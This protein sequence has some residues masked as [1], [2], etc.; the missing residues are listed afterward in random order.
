MLPTP[1]LLNQVKSFIQAKGKLSYYCLFL[2]GK[3]AGLRV[4]EAINFDLNLKKKSNLYLIRGKK[5]KKRA[6]FIDPSVINELKQNHWK[7]QQ[8]NRF[9]FAHFL[10][11]TK[12]ELNIG[13]EIELTPHTLRRCF[14]T[15]QANSGMPLPVLQ[16]VLG[17][18]SIR[19]TALYWKRTND[20]KEKVISDKWLVGKLPKEPSKPTENKPKEL[21]KL[22]ENNWKIFLN[23]QQ[24][25]NIFISKPSKNLELEKENKLLRE[26]VRQLEQN[27]INLKNDKENLTKQLIQ[28]QKTKENLLKLLTV[29][30]KQQQTLTQL[31]NNKQE[32]TP[33]LHQQLVAQIQVLAKY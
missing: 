20:P 6:V 27:I 3:E 33:E 18:S 30:L 23:I 15:Y 13:K 10:Q 17:H 4:S 1:Q 9:S 14:A 22:L 8:T 32:N 12:K 28:V 24:K 16:K 26:K 7:S 21:P 25:T 11:K 19:T 5:H 31:D 29:D 2:L